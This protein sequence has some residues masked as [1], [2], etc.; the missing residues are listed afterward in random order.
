MR[1]DLDIHELNKQIEKKWKK[2]LTN[3]GFVNSERLWELKLA[4]RPARMFKD[5]HKKTSRRMR[6]TEAENFIMK[7]V[8]LDYERID[9]YRFKQRQSSTITMQIN[10]MFKLEN[11][12]ILFVLVLA[13]E[14]QGIYSQGKNFPIFHFISIQKNFLLFFHLFKKTSAKFH[15]PFSS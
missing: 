15:V 13:Y 10:K 8:K 6:E 14:I 4:W 5:K 3:N 11:W 12:M 2:K 1:F 9:E 7:K